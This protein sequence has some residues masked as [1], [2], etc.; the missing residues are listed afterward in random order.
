MKERKEKKGIFVC[1]FILTVLSSLTLKT[2]LK[3]VFPTLIEFKFEGIRHNKYQL[4]A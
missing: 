3:Y 2:T 4:Q 1:S